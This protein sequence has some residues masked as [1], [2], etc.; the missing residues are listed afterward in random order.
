MIY[1][2]IKSLCNANGTSPTAL[3]ER[4]TGSKGNLPTWKK[5]N[6]RSE[7]LVT[8]AKE[9]NVS[10]DYLLGKTDTPYR[11][12]DRWEKDQYDDYQKAPSDTRKKLLMMWGC[13]SDLIGEA[14]RYS[15][16]D[17]SPQ[18]DAPVADT[19]L[20]FA[21]FGDREI[22]DEMLDDV[23]RYAAFVAQRKKEKD[24]SA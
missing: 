8:I 23:K 21:L 16:A 22:D 6:I 18:E 7:Y 13:P 24:G 19:A 9:F 4:L 15:P 20:M 10:T 3:C 11:L 1:E 17:P 12:V 2:R 14:R 5:G